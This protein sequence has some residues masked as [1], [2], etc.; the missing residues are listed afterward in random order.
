[1][2]A[3]PIY[4]SPIPGVDPVYF[5]DLPPSIEIEKCRENIHLDLLRG[6]NLEG[7]LGTL[8]LTLYY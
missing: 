5:A 1:M 3:A 8:P 2:E 7:T 4:V 6:F